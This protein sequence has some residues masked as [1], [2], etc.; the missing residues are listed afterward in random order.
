[1]GKKQKNDKN[2]INYFVLGFVKSRV[3]PGFTRVCHV[4]VPANTCGIRS[5]LCVLNDRFT[6]VIGSSR[7]IVRNVRQNELDAN[8]ISPDT[9][10][11]VLYLWSRVFLRRKHC[12]QYVRY[13]MIRTKCIEHGPINSVHRY[14]VWIKKI[15]FRYGTATTVKC[16]TKLRFYFINSNLE[17]TVKLLLFFLIC[18]IIVSFVGRVRIIKTIIYR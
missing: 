4:H 7:I 15:T 5:T 8:R 13:V 9:C 17:N 18:I 14:F 1:M 3:D 10:N 16:R 12:D 6:H 11:R 2:I